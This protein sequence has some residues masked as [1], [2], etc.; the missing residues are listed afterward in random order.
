SIVALFEKE[1]AD[2]D[3]INDVVL[4]VTLGEQML[5]SAKSPIHF[6]GKQRV[7]S[8]ADLSGMPLTAPGIVKIALLRNHAEIAVWEIPIRRIGDPQPTLFTAPAAPPRSAPATEP[9][10]S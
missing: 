2:P 5:L 3:V 4:Q 9:A 7:R 8:L 10:A 1:P 6:Q